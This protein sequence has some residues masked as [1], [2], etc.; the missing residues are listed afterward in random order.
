SGTSA[1]GWYGVEFLSSATSSI[2]DNAIVEET[3]IGI[4][5][6]STSGQT[7]QRTAIRTT[8]TGIRLST[9]PGAPLD[10]LMIT[11]AVNAVMVELGASPT[12]TNLAAQGSSGAAIYFPS[13][14]T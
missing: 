7:I 13:S 14:G 4:R 8:G 1:N 6:D 9:T 3:V 10:A 11:G 2:L 5:H 12:F